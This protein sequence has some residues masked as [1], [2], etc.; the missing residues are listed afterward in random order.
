MKAIKLI[1]VA[2]IAVM[3]A[4]FMSLTLISCGNDDEV[5]VQPNI[6]IVG[7]WKC[8][9]DS[10]YVLLTFS[11]NETSGTVR[12]QEYDHGRWEADET[13][14]Y[15]YSD[16]YLRMPELKDGDGAGVKVVSL[17]KN[18]LVLKDFL[19]GGNSTYYRQ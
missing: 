3:A 9:F 15:T 13:S 17:T 6:T 11:G 14:N 10:G 12:Y 16:G 18:T 1:S 8:T 7:R 19:D 4:T 5:T 2:A